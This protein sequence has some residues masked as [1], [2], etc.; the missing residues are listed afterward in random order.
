MPGFGHDYGEVFN[1]HADMLQILDNWVEN[2]VAP[3]E[4]IAEDQNEATYG[5]TQILKAFK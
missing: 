2:G 3:K 1:V 4:I 5:R